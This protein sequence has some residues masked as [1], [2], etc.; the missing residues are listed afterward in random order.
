MELLT[1]LRSL[2]SSDH[3]RMRVLR[4]VREL[5]LPDCWVSAGFVRSCVWDHLHERLSSPLR[6]DV[7]V[8][9]HDPS[10]ATPERD[11]VLESILRARDGTL[12]WSVKNQARMHVRN[13]DQPYSCALDAMRH[14]PETAT[15]VGVRL[16]EEGNIDVAAPY[17]LA[18]LF[19]LVV[20]PTERFMTEKRAIYADRIRAKRWQATWPRLTID[21]PF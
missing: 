12:D 3:R 20:R 13:R 14:W 8:V 1:Q 10:Q 11:A 19:A 15:A 7:D 6:G 2:I 17:S 4:I 9:W 18:D 21:M 5:T 16:D